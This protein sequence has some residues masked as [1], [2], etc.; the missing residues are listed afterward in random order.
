MRIPKRVSLFLHEL[1]KDVIDGSIHC[2]RICHRYC[3][4][5]Q[6]IISGPFKALFLISVSQKCNFF[7]SLSG[8][9][10]KIVSSKSPKNQV[11]E[12]ALN[13]F[14]NKEIKIIL[15]IFFFSVG[16]LDRCYIFYDSGLPYHYPFFF[17]Y[18]TESV[19]RDRDIAHFYEQK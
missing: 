8:C 13:S 15:L 16:S 11:N 10:R 19:P 2:A 18:I 7:Y 5:C 12:H 3:F 1:S 4:K 17:I 9:Q 6:H 14:E